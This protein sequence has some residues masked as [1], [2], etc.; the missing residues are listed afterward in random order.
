MML[1]DDVQSRRFALDAVEA[2]LDAITFDVVGAT[3]VATVGREGVA[4]EV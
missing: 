2:S 1:R 3:Q 4:D